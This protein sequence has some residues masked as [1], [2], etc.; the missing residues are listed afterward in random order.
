MPS[1]KGTFAQLDGPSDDG[2]TPPNEEAL[3]VARRKREILAEAALNPTFLDQDALLEQRKKEVKEAAEKSANEEPVLTEQ[4]EDEVVDLINAGRKEKFIEIFGRKIHLR[5]LS[6]AEEL[7]VSELT[8]PYIGSDGY[9]RAYRT[10]VVAAAIRTIDGKLLFNPISESEF[11]QIIAK[12]FDK[13]LDYYPLAVDQIF[14]RY[15]EMEK[16]LFELV[17]KLGKSSG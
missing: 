11:E 8:K 3:I 7:K 12:K 10:A 16:E 4:E 1:G 6:I 14:A 5:T 9:H 13:L 15:Q 2:L 17:Q